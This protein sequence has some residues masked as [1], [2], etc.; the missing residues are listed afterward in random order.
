MHDQSQHH[1]QHFLSSVHTGHNNTRVAALNVHDPK[2]LMVA[3]YFMIL[4]LSLVCLKNSVDLKL[5]HSERSQFSGHE[6]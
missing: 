5:R 1:K 4:I 2:T 6:M 3:L